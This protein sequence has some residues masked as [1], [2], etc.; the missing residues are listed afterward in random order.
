MDL[1][2]ERLACARALG[3]DGLVEQVFQQARQRMSIPSDGN[4]VTIHGADGSTTRWS[5]EHLGR[6]AASG[7]NPRSGLLAEL[8]EGVR[9]RLRQARTNPAVTDPHTVEAVSR[10]YRDYPD[11]QEWPEFARRRFPDRRVSPSAED[12]ARAFHEWA[13]GQFVTGSGRRASVTAQSGT[14]DIPAGKPIEKAPRADLLPHASDLI[15]RGPGEPSGT[16]ADA[17]AQRRA[18]MEERTR[19]QEQLSQENNPDVRAGLEKRLREL[20]P[21]INNPTEDLGEATGRQLV[22]DLNLPEEQVRFDR[23]AGAPDIIAFDPRN[24]ETGRVTVVECKGGDSPL[25]TRQTADGRLAQQGTFEYLESLAADMQKPPNGPRAAAGRALEAA[26][27]QV[28]P[29]VDFVV[30][31]QPIN[32]DGS[33]GTPVVSRYNI[34]TKNSSR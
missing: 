31:R 6:I 10:R 16:V 23:G 3:D 13:S 15:P 26:L 28:P 4:I 29:N 20:I 34:S 2:V 8:G 17:I 12:L 22:K 1:L 24:P 19:V 33:L 21:L 7:D 27:R 11:F 25:G 14:P 30:V 9:A 32:P 5:L 18:A